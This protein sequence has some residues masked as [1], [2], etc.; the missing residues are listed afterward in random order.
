MHI[1]AQNRA[2]LYFQPHHSS[3]SSGVEAAAVA[4]SGVEAAAVAETWCIR[5]E[6]T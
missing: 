3:P 1:L 2:S 5:H 4:T 6:N